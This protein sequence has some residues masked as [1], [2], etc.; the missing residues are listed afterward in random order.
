MRD[1][2]TV[3]HGYAFDGKYF[4]SEGEYI[5]LTPGNFFDE[6]GF[7]LKENEKYYTGEIPDGYLLNR[8]DLLIA[9]TEQ[10]E[11]LLGSS[12]IIP[13]SGKYLHNQRLGL[14]TACQPDLIDLRFLYHLFNTRH[15]RAQIRASAS[16]VKVRHT[17]PSRIGE[18]RVRIPSVSTQRKIAAVLSTYDDLIENNT[19]RIAILEAM[20]QAIYR[21]WFVEFHFPGH[22]KTKLVNSPL[23]KIPEGWKIAKLFDVAEVAYGFPYKSKH[24]TTEPVGNPV[25]RIRD[26]L[27]HRSNTYTSEDAGARYIRLFRK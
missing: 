8:G 12:A 22:E 3:K 21:E 16:G 25:I 18:V 10:A 1:L 14:I 5:L 26:I 19:R 6:G 2:F 17:S 4:T 23:G 9:M 27:D 24:F 7:K 13:E 11:G 20:A 15:V